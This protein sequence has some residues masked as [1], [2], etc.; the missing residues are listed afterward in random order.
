[1]NIFAICF[2]VALNGRFTVFDTAL[3]MCFWNSA[4]ILTCCSGF[5]SIDVTNIFFMSFGISFICFMLP[6]LATLSRSSSLYS[7]LLLSSFSNSLFI[8][9]NI[10]L[11]IIFLSN[12]SANNG[13]IALEVPAMMLIVPVGAIVVTVA[14][15]MCLYFFA[16]LLF[17]LFGKFPF[18][19]PSSSDFF[20]ASS[21]M[22]FIVFSAVFTAS[23]D[24]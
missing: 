23:S 20:L 6:A 14:F 15:L 22:N 11:S 4:C 3:S 21:F 13:S 10:L 16:S 8:S 2:F 1:M 12:I 19:F 9:K 24:L 17:S 7:P 18:C 5:M